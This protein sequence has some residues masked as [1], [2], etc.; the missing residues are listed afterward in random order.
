MQLEGAFI[1]YKHTELPIE[2]RERHPTS[3]SVSA[4]LAA[5]LYFNLQCSHFVVKKYHIVDGL[6]RFKNVYV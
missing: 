1:L 4:I 3:M 5:S 6:G 2:V